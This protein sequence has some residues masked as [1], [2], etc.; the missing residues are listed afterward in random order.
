MK[1]L[2]INLDKEKDR[3]AFQ[4]RQMKRLGLEYQ[5]IRATRAQDVNPDELA[6]R[7][8]QWERPMRAG[9]VA[10]LDS[11]RTAWQMV[12]DSKKPALI[13]ED[14]AFLSSRVPAILDLLQNQVDA[15]HVTLEI[16]S[17]KKILAHTPLK[18]DASTNLTRLYQ[19]RTGAA[20][21]VLW[22]RGAQ[23]LLDNSTRAAG[24]ADAIIA[25]AYQMSSWQIEPA[26]AMQLDQCEAY[27]IVLPLKT[28][29]SIGTSS[30]DKPSPSGAFSAFKFKWRRVF[31][32]LRMGLRQLSTITK[33]NRRLV[34]VEIEDFQVH[35]TD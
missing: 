20:A 2:I 12:K 35:I 14:D 31:S 33:A 24:L 11:H 30:H 32:Q 16:R 9:E 25:A 5:R 7:S 1:I 29:S 13:L 21:Y 22:P 23:I 26:A 27:G 15:H 28:T 3:M 8:L 6:A 17:R 18:L 34:A 19:D 4:R 10:C